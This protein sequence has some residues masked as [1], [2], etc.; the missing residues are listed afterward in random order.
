M[1]ILLHNLSASS[2]CSIDNEHS[3]DAPMT[4]LAHPSRLKQLISLILMSLCAQGCWIETALSQIVPDASLGTE[5]SLSTG[6]V[7][8]GGSQRGANLF[9][10]FAQFNI[11]DRQRIDFANPAGVDRIFARVTGNTRSEILGTLGILGNADLFL[12]NPNGIT[13]GANAALDVRGSFVA[14]TA[15]SLIFDNGFSFSTVTPQTPPLLTISA[16]L[17]LQY[18]SNLSSIQ[19]QRAS[20][21][22]SDGKRLALLGGDVSLEGSTLLALSGQVE[23]GEPQ[24]NV[25]LSA[26]TSVDVSGTGSGNIAINARNITISEGSRLFA[27]IASNTIGDAKLAGGIRLNAIEAINLNDSE[28]L[29]FVLPG[30]VGNSGNVDISTNSLLINNG[31]QINITTAGQGNAGNVNINVVN[32]VRLSQLSPAGFQSAIFSIAGNNA[33][34]NAGN[35][36]ISAGE[37]YLNDYSGLSTVLREGAIG[38][39]GDIN[40]TTGQLTFADFS[41]LNAATFGQGD[42]GNISVKVNGAISLTNGSAIANQ[43]FPD[44]IGNVGNITIEGHSLSLT[45]GSEILAN[46]APRER[47]GNIIVNARDSISLIGIGTEGI[48]QGVSSGLFSDTTSDSFGIGGSIQV[49]A[50]SLMIADGAVIDAGSR[51]AARGGDI[52]INVDRLRITGGGQILTTAKSSG[53]AGDIAVQ[54]AS[55]IFLSGRDPGFETRLAQFGAEVV[56]QIDAASGIFAN[57]LAGSSGTG[58]NI[59][60]R[61]RAV[62]VQEDARVAVDSQGVGA[63]GSIQVQ[64]NLL[65][66]SDRAAISAETQSNTGGNI[67]LSVPDLLLLRRGSS[68]STTA[69]IAQ[70]NG[71]GGNINLTSGFIVAIP[72]ENSDITANAFSGRGGNITITTQGIFGTDFRD[73]QTALSD[74]TASS[75]LGINGVVTINTLALDPLQGTSELPTRFSSPPIAQGCQASSRTSR[76]VNQ[77]RGGVS[78]SPADPLVA[79]MIWQD[80]ELIDHSQASHNPKEITEAQGWVKQSD[81]T[82][83]LVA[84]PDRAMN[85]CPTSQPIP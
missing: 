11:G 66:L 48:A 57:T 58:G 69:G 81:G 67:T 23:L 41:V 82:V 49:N 18:P 52:A 37:L 47:A 16:P 21:Q 31:G 17:G 76:F 79:E 33:Q 36:N 25:S 51:N 20:L 38:K 60:V 50:P 59:S 1:T 8:T 39:A 85:D 71:D 53:Q 15:N 2:S 61:S 77:G 63:G 64:T 3:D 84:N 14:S 26:G 73:R 34:G 56:D 44:A 13:F 46:G 7:I 72:N 78:I 24:G 10:S 62:R 19:L 4:E 68:I 43:V 29:I 54:A 30:A 35:I 70:G 42:S 55:D 32:S 12:L 27:G 5:S 22:V 75:Q 9:H 80:W 45:S 6:N 40:I 65:T 74:I 28:I 83:A